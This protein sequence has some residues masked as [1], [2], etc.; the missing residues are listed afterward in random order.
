MGTSKLDL[1]QVLNYFWAVIPASDKKLTR[2]IVLSEYRTGST[3][4]TDFINQ[5][6][7]AFCDGE[8]FLDFVNNKKT[9]MLFPV[10][11]SEGYFKKPRLS[12]KISREK[13]THY[14]FDLK[15][16]QIHRGVVA[17][18][19]DRHKFLDRITRKGWKIIVI[20]RQNIVKQSISNLVA[21]ERKEWHDRPKNPLNRKRVWIDICVFE[22]EIERRISAREVL[23]SVVGSCQTLKITYEDDLLNSG[24]HQNTANKVF[25]YLDLPPTQVK[26]RLRKVSSVKISDDVE[27]Y[28]DIIAFIQGSKYSKYLEDDFF[29]I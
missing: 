3:L 20:D 25:S 6:P 24:N 11:Y 21:Q 9:K 13:I 10:L 26:A 16:S 15:L 27:N 4:L 22:N 2:F 8:I 7:L 5:H 29:E 18:N 19:N 1:K 23:R 17:W 28:G 14:G 12:K